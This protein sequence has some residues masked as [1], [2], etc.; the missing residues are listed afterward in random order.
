MPTDWPMRMVGCLAMHSSPVSFCRQGRHI[1]NN[2]ACTPNPFILL[3]QMLMCAR[4][5]SGTA[6][7]PPPVPATN[8][9]SGCEAVD[10]AP[11]VDAPA[12]A[13]SSASAGK[14]TTSTVGQ[15][16]PCWGLQGSHWGRKL[17][18]SELQMVHC[19]LSR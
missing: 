14:S 3:Y 1:T 16:M 2:T 11:V 13:P 15:C 5:A 18:L 9:P 8:V 19:K 17:H 10:A 7:P 12:A 4:G 6:S